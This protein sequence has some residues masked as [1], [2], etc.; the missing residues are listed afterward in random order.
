MKYRTVLLGLTAV[1][2]IAIL[3]ASATLAQWGG[4]GRMVPTSAPAKLP[5]PSASLSANP[6]SISTGAS[7]TLTWSSTNAASCAGTNFSTGGAASGNTSVSPGSTTTYSIN[8]NGA[9][10]SATVTVTGGGGGGVTCNSPAVPG[11]AAAAGFTVLAG[12]SDFTTNSGTNYVVNGS[13]STINWTNLA[14]WLGGCGG[15]GSGYRWVYAYYYGSTPSCGLIDLETDGTIGKQVLHGR[16]NV[17]D[18]NGRW[19]GIT[20]PDGNN[21]YGGP[22]PNGLPF[23]YYVEV[24][25]RTT[26]A[27]LSQSDNQDVQN[28]YNVFSG[29]GYGAFFEKDYFEVQ[30][31]QFNGSTWLIGDGGIEWGPCNNGQC[32]F[33]NGQTDSER[34]DVT[35]Y[36][37]YGSLFTSDG[38]SQVWKCAYLDGAAATAN[39]G[40]LQTFVTPGVLSQN[41]DNVALFMYGDNPTNNDV[42]VYIQSFR[43]WVCPGS[44]GT[45]TQCTNLVTHY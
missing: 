45:S 42:H 14:N 13:G 5:P 9:T 30:S 34:S 15:P 33:M 16:M 19:I 28:F 4:G 6:T 29:S 24:T 3:A 2:F 36:H 44:F 12:C 40:T 17:G 25:Y 39:C 31:G 18:S 26:S 20:W 38:T 35:Q 43:F 21:V 41:H 37:T 8:C 27:S 22:G 32:N 10:A 23:S 7:S 11:P 1:L